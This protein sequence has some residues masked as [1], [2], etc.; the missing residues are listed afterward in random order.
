MLLNFKFEAQRLFYRVRYVDFVNTTKNKGNMYN[1][2]EEKDQALDFSFGIFL[3]EL[4]SP[5]SGSR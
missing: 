3:S 4:Q 5:L 1:Q 2:N